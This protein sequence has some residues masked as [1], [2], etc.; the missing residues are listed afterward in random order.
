MN[1]F[2]QNTLIL[3][4]G[5]WSLLTAFAQEGTPPF[6]PPAEMQESPKP[7]EKTPEAE[8]V[9]EI[10]VSPTPTPTV[11]PSPEPEPA[12]VLSPATAPAPAP[13]RL[14]GFAELPAKVQELVLGAFRL[15][16][17]NLSY[18][19]GAADPS[20]GGMD[21][22]GTVYY[23]L[24]ELG[25]KNVPRQA[26]AFYRWVWQSG[27]FV[28]VNGTTFDSYEW[29]NLRPGDLL[30]WT[31]TYAVSKDRDPAI[32]HVMIYLGVDQ[33]TG[34]RVMF[35]ASDGRR[36]QDKSRSGVGLFDF[37]L[38]VIGKTD[39]GRQPR[40]IGYGRIPDPPEIKT[41]QVTKP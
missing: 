12:K 3:L 15:N 35:G 22:S 26:D 30:F 37:N 34:R 8:P 11:T 24:R 27:Q 29:K 23:L 19:Y 39:S 17:L 4:L 25:W 38:P 10:P 28:A 16:N 21:C 9:T 41:S 31:G 2:P 36:Y 13:V 20:L 5:A 7:V 14:K 1:R 40:F 18:K 6:T 33:D 32:S